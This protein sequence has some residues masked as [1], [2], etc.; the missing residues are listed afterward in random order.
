MP[1][2][3]SEQL[4][5]WALGRLDLAADATAAETFAATASALQSHGFVPA[6]PLA[7]ALDVIHGSASEVDDQPPGFAIDD[8]QR[9]L[10]CVAQF[11][12]RMFALSPADRTAAWQALMTETSRSPY[13]HA[14]VA[15]LRRG[16]RVDTKVLPAD[17]DDVHELAAHLFSL[18]PL[19]TARKSSRR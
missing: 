10:D 9:L 1:A 15:A 7:D 5:N 17:D 4:R 8:E 3:Q 16:L 14:L 13:P 2:N 6:A 19:P 18:F 11:G 12:D